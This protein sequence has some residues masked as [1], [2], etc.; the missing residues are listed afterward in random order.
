MSYSEH[1]EGQ[2]YWHRSDDSGQDA[3]SIQAD[4]D[5]EKSKAIAN[6]EPKDIGEVLYD[7]AGMLL[8][9][10]RA[11]LQGESVVAQATIGKAVCDAIRKY[12]EDSADR[13]IFGRVTRRL[14]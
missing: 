10:A 12:A 11:D 5:F 2:A 14:P 7:C 8:I 3:A 4:W 13:S 1:S 6:L 9:L